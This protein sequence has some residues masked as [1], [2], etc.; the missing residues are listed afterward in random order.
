MSESAGALLHAQARDD[1]DLLVAL[2]EVET[3]SPFTAAADEQRDVEVRDAGEVG[4]VG[5]DL[6]PHGERRLAPVVAHAGRARAARGRSP[7]ARSRAGAGPPVSSPEMRIGDRDAD[8][9]AG[10]ELPH[11]DARAGHLAAQRRLQRADQLVGVVLVAD[12]DDDL[13]VV[14]LRLLGGDREPEPR[15]RR[16][17]RTW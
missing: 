3:G 10:L 9:L 12:L 14:E 13:R 7:A 11:V 1:R 15:A 17:R 16:R 8:R 2:A 4:A 5:V 6:E